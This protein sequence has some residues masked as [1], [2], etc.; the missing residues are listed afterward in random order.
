MEVLLLERKK[1]DLERELTATRKEREKL[2]ERP[3]LAGL[4]PPAETPEELGREADEADWHPWFLAA[5]RLG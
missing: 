1:E 2:E 3:E 5:H 4:P